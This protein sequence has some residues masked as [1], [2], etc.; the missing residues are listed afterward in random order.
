MKSI[1]H[2]ELFFVKSISR[3][4]SIMLNVFRYW[5]AQMITPLSSMICITYNTF[6]KTSF[7]KVH[8]FYF[9]F[10]FFAS[11]YCFQEGEKNKLR[12]LL[13]DR[14]KKYSTAFRLFFLLAYMNMTIN[15]R[16]CFFWQFSTFLEFFVAF[17]YG[18]MDY[19]I[20]TF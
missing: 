19:E 8:R 20:N 14:E 13:F 7:S 15:F 9:F 17:V 3:N 10:S 5:R 4:F 18:L 2:L 6:L 12:I 16:L 1:S 11:F